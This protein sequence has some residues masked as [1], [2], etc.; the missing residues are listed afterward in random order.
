MNS[1]ASASLK[2]PSHGFRDSR[3]LKS[4][5]ERKDLPGILCR[6]CY[7]NVKNKEYFSISVAHL[8]DHP[9]PCPLVQIEKLS[10]T[11]NLFRFVL[12]V[13]SEQARMQHDV[14]INDIKASRLPQLLFL[15][16]LGAIARIVSRG[17]QILYRPFLFCAQC[18]YSMIY[19]C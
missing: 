17:K 2:K 6:F 4:S 9:P 10:C 3:H 7:F 19:N 13:N 15:F 12:H 5:D 8:S 14:I 16:P 18:F 11:N 1:N